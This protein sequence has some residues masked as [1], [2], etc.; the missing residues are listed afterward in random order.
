MDTTDAVT[1]VDAVKISSKIGHKFYSFIKRFMDIIFSLIGLIFLLPI[2][3]IVKII[4][5]CNKDFHPIFFKQKRIGKNGKLFNFYKFRSMVPNADEVLVK[6]L[7][8]D[9]EAAKENKINKKLENDRRINKIGK[10][11]ARFF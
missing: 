7:K 2:A 3:L 6:L 9:K 8:E 11:L 4:Y 1:T 10:I 5:M